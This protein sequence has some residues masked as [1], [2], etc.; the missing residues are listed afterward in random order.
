VGDD[1]VADDHDRG[2]GGS[3]EADHAGEWDGATG[4]HHPL[5][6]ADE[7]VLLDHL[8][9]GWVILGVGAGG[10]IPSDPYVVGVE[11]SELHLRFAAAFDAM[12]RLFE[13]TEPS[14]METEWLAMREAVL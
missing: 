2:G 4:L 11:A 10:V 8:T 5:Y 1:C 3:D 7:Y 9:R 13:S 14:R 12:M 6:V